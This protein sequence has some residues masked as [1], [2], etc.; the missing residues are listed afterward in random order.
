MANPKV[1]E[2]FRSLSNTVVR[3][4]PYAM[5]KTGLVSAQTILKIENYMLICSR[6]SWR[7]PCMSCSDGDSGAA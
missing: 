4:S 7:F 5:T 1:Q 2:Y 3:L 6:C